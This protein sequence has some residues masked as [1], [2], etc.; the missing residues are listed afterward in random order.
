M[1]LTN[2]GFPKNSPVPLTQF[3]DYN[4]TEWRRCRLGAGPRVIILWCGL[5]RSRI[6][7][8]R[9]RGSPEYIWRDHPRRVGI[10]LTRSIGPPEYI[11]WGRE[12]LAE[13]IWWGRGCR[14]TGKWRLRHQGPDRWQWDHLL[15]SS[16]CY[17]PAD[18]RDPNVSDPIEHLGNMSRGAPRPLLS[19]CILPTG[20]WNLSYIHGVG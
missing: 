10:R 4:S 17:P 12:V 14:G 2:S 18:Q 15:M 7:L 6:H 16:R 3:I 13:Y 19:T 11:W 20:E 8:T 5:S 1:S 9:S